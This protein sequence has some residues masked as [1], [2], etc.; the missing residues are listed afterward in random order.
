MWKHMLPS[1][2]LILSAAVFAGEAADSQQAPEQKPDA[3]AISKRIES[4][5]QS[6]VVRD[7][8][9]NW[10]DFKTIDAAVLNDVMKEIVRSAPDRNPRIR[11]LISA[12]QLALNDA[13]GVEAMENVR[14]IVAVN[15]PNPIYHEA[16][17]PTIDSLA[18]AG[19]AR[20]LPFL[21]QDAVD[22]M[23]GQRFGA[24]NTSETNRIFSL[25]RLDVHRGDRIKPT[26][27]RLKPWIERH[28]SDL[29]WDAAN[30]WYVSSAGAPGFE[31]A[32]RVEKEFGLKCVD[33]LRS[34]SLERRKLI[35]K[36]YEMM[37][38]DPKARDDQNVAG[39][40]HEIVT[41]E[42][43]EPTTMDSIMAKE[44][45][46]HNQSLVVDV[47][48]D[49]IANQFPEDNRC[50]GLI[51]RTLWETPELVEKACARLAPAYEDAWQAALKSG[52]VPKAFDAAMKLIFFGGR[53]DMARIAE[54]V[55][56]MPS[57]ADDPFRNWLSL[58]RDAGRPGYLRMLILWAVLEPR[59]LNSSVT[60]FTQGACWEK[61]D[62][63]NGNL[64]IRLAECAAWLD[65]NEHRLIYDI[66][67]ETFKGG[68]IPGRGAIA[69]ILG[70]IP[71]EY[72]IR[73]DEV[74]SGGR[75]AERDLYRNLMKLVVDHAEAAHNKAVCDAL[76]ALA[77]PEDTLQPDQSIFANEFPK[78]CPEVAARIYAKL[79][80][81][82]LQKKI[83]PAE[84]MDHVAGNFECAPS[85]WI[86]RVNFV[87]QN[88][89]KQMDVILASRFQT[90][91][92]EPGIDADVRAKRTMA[93]VF[94]GGQLG[95]AEVE[96]IMSD[97]SDRLAA[98]LFASWGKAIAAKG[99][100]SGLHVLLL[101]AKKHANALEALESTLQLAGMK[102]KGASWKVSSEERFQCCKDWF[103]DNEKN[104]VWD[105]GFRRFI[106][107]KSA[108]SPAS[109][110]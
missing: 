94:A 42:P 55:K 48:A 82:D 43:L 28:L 71:K 54:L 64:Q 58:C 83:G 80:E 68:I 27:L 73:I 53:P 99:Y 67:T 84:I 108:A 95:D 50:L 44:L 60:Q 59:M 6:G 18:G 105:A 13:A 96:K 29:T 16:C 106:L 69:E 35:R 46:K 40:F 74:L 75:F 88:V 2:L 102:P 91:R 21:A 33:L 89:L 45:A 72:D 1:A 57:L 19:V 4:W 101:A 103:A 100:L 110:K 70:R 17:Y 109:D 5:L 78:A 38:S 37:R 3:A 32:L 49:A 85:V 56:K 87:D 51:Y 10:S 12:L 9:W 77:D 24:L 63:T 36:L 14:T 81:S 76:F 22:S 62:S 90:L 104:L 66:P 47:V 92:L 26:L 86:E 79:V 20:A 25:L 15:P 11:F 107:R 34:D 39:L 23:A 7:A 41:S 98:I 93:Y 30:H 52:D 61:W 31:Y 8:P 97:T 65:E